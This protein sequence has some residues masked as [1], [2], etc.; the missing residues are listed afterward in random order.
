M[1]RKP[2]QYLEKTRNRGISL[3]YELGFVSEEIANIFNLVFNHS[4]TFQR[5]PPSNHSHI[6]G[7]SHWYQ[8]FR[9]EHTRVSQFSPLLQLRM[10]PENLHR[11][12]RIRVVRRLE[13][14]LCNPN[15][16]K[17]SA[18]GSDEVSQSQAAVRH[19]ALHLVELAQVRG[20]HGFVAEDTIDAEVLL[21]GEAAL[22]VG[23]SVR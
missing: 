16:F 17:K 1:Q 6:R 2:L 14:N 21:R 22:L 18:N 7:K 9:T 20:V 15:F 10:V 13:T 5:K 12:L 11:R 8:H 23:K 3:T 4:W 19:H